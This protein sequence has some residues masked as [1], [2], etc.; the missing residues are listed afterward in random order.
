MRAYL[1]RTQ[2]R[3]T[4]QTLFKRK[5]SHHFYDIKRLKCAH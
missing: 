4:E 2:V 1:Y 5:E 3:E